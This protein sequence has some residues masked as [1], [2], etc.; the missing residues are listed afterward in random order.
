VTV[1]AGFDDFVVMRSPRLLRTAYLLTHDW[2]LAEDL[3]QTALARAWEAWHRIDGDPEPY[4]R[5]I[6]VNSYASWWRRRWTGE[7]PTE[8]LPEQVHTADPHRGVDERDRLWRA[9]RQLPRRQR[10]VLVLRYFEDMSEAEIADALGCS[11]GTV[12]SKASRALAKLRLD[13]NLA[14]EGLLR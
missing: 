8:V 2:A 7:L 4:V 9:V 10:A 13:E 1:S 5:R 14:P 11:L 12:K 3:V 6:I